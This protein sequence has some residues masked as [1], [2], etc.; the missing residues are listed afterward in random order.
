MKHDTI[1][2][3][4]VDAFTTRPFSGNTAGVVTH[5][6]ERLTASQMQAIAREMNVAETAFLLPPSRAE[7]D[8]RIRWFT[9]AKEVSLCGHATVASFH[10]AAEEGSWGLEHDGVTR[11]RMECLSGILPIE[12]TKRG[13]DPAI[14]RMGLPDPPME[15]WPD[16]SRALAALGL[17]PD[18]RAADLAAVRCGFFSLVPV[19]SLAALR[20]I[21]PSMQAVSEVT[22]S[23]GGDGLIV[24]SLETIDSGSAV[25]VRMF[26]PAAGVDEDPVTGS[27]EGP[28]AGW[29]ARIGYFA[30]GDARF[31]RLADG[32]FAYTAEQG[33]IIGRR[34][35]IDVELSVINEGFVSRGHG[36]SILGRAVTVMEGTIRVP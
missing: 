25:H 24:A 3:R 2:I 22:T 35:R 34:G 5:G 10:S 16:P 17:A 21:R 31:R 1:A 23:M 11:I 6:G 12:V 36:I 27:A 20:A 26:A 4:K 9:P 7:A 8:L 14:V 33:D 18:H 13:D 29:L 19:K 30:R 28:I 32:R 15:E